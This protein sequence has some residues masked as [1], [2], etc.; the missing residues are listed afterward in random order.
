MKTIAFI[1]TGKMATALISCICK[2]NISRNII[3][4]DKN[5]KNLISIKKQYKIRITTDNKEAV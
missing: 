1:G 3:A 4:S 5:N 2:N